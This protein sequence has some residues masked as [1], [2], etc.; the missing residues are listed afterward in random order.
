MPLK[1][2]FSIL[3]TPPKAPAATKKRDSRKM[4]DL[5]CSV[6]M[7]K[8]IEVLKAQEQKVQ[9]DVTAKKIKRD[10]EG[11][12]IDV[13]VRY[14]FLRTDQRLT[15]DAM[16]KFISRNRSSFPQFK[17]AACKDDQLE[18][19]LGAFE[20]EG[21]RRVWVPAAPTPPAP[22]VQE[23]ASSQPPALNMV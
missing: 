7:P 13:L 5:P 18:L 22:Q 15:L 6:D 16:K 3:I 12:V 21:A 1:M 2:F 10:Q 19:L 14:G 4:N 23:I 8:C 20:G 17:G 9:A 11:P